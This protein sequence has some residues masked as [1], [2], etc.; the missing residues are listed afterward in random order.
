WSNDVPPTDTLSAESDV[1]CADLTTSG[2]EA[3][4]PA[5]LNTA[6]VTPAGAT[7]GQFRVTPGGAA[8]YSIPLRVLPGRMGMAPS[9]LTIVYDSGLGDG[10]MGP[11]F[12]LTG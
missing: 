3:Q 10:V 7:P 12:Q 1:A 6:Q 11:G 8:A 5:A 4:L 2:A 9:D